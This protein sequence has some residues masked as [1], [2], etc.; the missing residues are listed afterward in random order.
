MAVLETLED[1]L[2]GSGSDLPAQFLS[3][4][5][6]NWHQ[7]SLTPDKDEEVQRCP[8]VYVILCED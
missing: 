7:L 3:T 5:G 4:F 8:E 1:L 2:D 6:S